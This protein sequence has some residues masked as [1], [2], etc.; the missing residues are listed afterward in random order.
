MKTYA[1]ATGTGSY[2]PPVVVRNVDFAGQL[3]LNSDGTKNRKLPVR[4][5]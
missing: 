4:R 2:I 5:L 1:V 3:F